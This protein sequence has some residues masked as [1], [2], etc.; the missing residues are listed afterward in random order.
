MS[1]ATACLLAGL[2]CS[3]TGPITRGMCNKHYRRALQVG[4]IVRLPIIDPL[5]RYELNENGCWVWTGPLSAG[6]YAIW[7]RRGRW[8]SAHRAFYEIYVSSIPEGLV[9]DHLC[10][11]RA[12]VNPDHLEPVTH[13]KNVRRGELGWGAD[14]LCR[15]GL[16]DITDPVN[17]YV[18]ATEI[19]QK[20]RC[21]ECRRVATAR[22]KLKRR[23]AARGE[24]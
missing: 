20:R 16:H 12:C 14:G 24:P 17:V 22:S 10:R 2:E 13:D 3:K 11:N 6:G 9:I 7:H 8:A 4:D 5:T 18:C 19:P 23:E 1:E 15:Q 21:R